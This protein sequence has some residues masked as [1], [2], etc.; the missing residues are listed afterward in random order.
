MMK[1]KGRRWDQTAAYI[2]ERDDWT[3]QECGDWGN[4][5]DHIEPV[6]DG[7]AMWSGDNLQ[8]LCRSC[9]IDKSRAELPWQ[10]SGRAEWLERVGD[11]RRE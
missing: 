6:S 7:G 2:R 9:H 3:C 10:T 8:V 1:R 4:E 5:V 11:Y